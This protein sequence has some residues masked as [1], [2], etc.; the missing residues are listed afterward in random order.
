[1][2]L[3][4][5]FYDRETESSTA[6]SPANFLVYSIETLCNPS[7]VLIWNSDALIYDF[8]ASNLA[9]AL[10]SNIN[11]A[12]IRTIPNRIGYEIGDRAL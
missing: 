1:M 8:E 4:D 12:T 7:D 5:V 2:P 3:Q 11:L 10:P 9:H 6:V